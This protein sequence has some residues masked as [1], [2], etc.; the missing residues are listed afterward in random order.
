MVSRSRCPRVV[1]RANVRARTPEIT[2]RC[3]WVSSCP[4]D[5]SYGELSHPMQTARGRL[6]VLPRGDCRCRCVVAAVAAVPCL[7][8]VIGGARPPLS[9][10]R[11]S[12]PR[13]VSSNIQNVAYGSAVAGINIAPSLT[14]GTSPGSWRAW[15]RYSLGAVSIRRWSLDRA[16]RH[17][18]RNV[19]PYAPVR[20]N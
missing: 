17:G 2:R 11:G 4:A 5:R 13:D 18:Q 19:R 8:D 7:A 3:R 10:S 6:R 15:V 9:Y 12:V 1:D 20:S 16:A 14:R